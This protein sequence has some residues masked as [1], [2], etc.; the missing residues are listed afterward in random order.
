[1]AIEYRWAEGQYDR[2]PALAADLVR[3]QVAVIV[4]T[5]GDP[6]ALAAKAATTT[7]PIVF[8]DRQRP[9]QARPRR[10]PQPTGRQ[11]HRRNYLHRH[12]LSA[13][14]L[15]L[16]RELVPGRAAIGVLVNPTVPATA[17]PVEQTCRR[18]LAPSGCKFTSCDA[19]TEREIDTAFAALPSSRVRRARRS[20]PTRSSPAGAIKLAALAARHAVPRS[21][22]VA[23]MPPPAA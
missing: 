16:L 4:A 8:S 22:E 9:G 3:R 15:E 12:D 18:R 10:E 14:R 21:T 17:R 7:I 2:L 6:A 13:K 20:P 1:M 19:S 23:N 5:G 11:R